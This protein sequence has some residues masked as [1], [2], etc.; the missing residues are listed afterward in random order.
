MPKGYL[1]MSD[2]DAAILGLRGENRLLKA[3]NELLRSALRD[4]ER[5]SGDPKRFAAHIQEILDRSNIR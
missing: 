4:I 5:M 2:V 3:E 1:T